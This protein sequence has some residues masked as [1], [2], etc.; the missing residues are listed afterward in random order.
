LTIMMNRRTSS[1]RSR[2][3]A[4]VVRASALAPLGGLA[5][6]GVSAKLVAGCATGATTSD[7][8]PVTIASSS[9]TSGSG[10]QGGDDATASSSASSSSGEGGAGGQG[11]ADPCAMGCAAGLVD[12]DGDAATGECGCEYACTKLS[13]DD[14]VDAAFTDDNCDG[15]DGV[16]AD[17]VYVSKKLGN[18]MSDG[19]RKVPLD[20]L[21]AAL[22]LAVGSGKKAVCVAG[23]V[24]GAI[25]D[26][27]VTLASGVSLY[28]GFDAEDPTFAFR[29]SDKVPTVLRAEGVVVLASAI[30]VDT[31]LEGF[32][33]RALKTPLFSGTTYGVRLV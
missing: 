27:P 11:G 9:V 3:L 13:D 24:D 17:C 7:T 23:T 29:R 2:S 21:D 4:S 28:G 32:E 30:D 8:D 14:H 26:G 31:H 16:V 10:G 18:A 6:L 25:H 20:T 5:P 1:A 15:S 22:K 12:L 19:T 33:L